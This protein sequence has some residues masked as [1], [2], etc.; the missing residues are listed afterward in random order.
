[1]NSVTRRAVSAFVVLAVTFAA[2]A[3]FASAADPATSP[4]DLIYAPER[5]APTVLAPFVK[6]ERM[7]GSHWPPI[8]DSPCVCAHKMVG[9]DARACRKWVGAPLYECKIRG[10][11]PES[12]CVKYGPFLPE[13]Y[14]PCLHADNRRECYVFAPPGS[15]CGD[16]KFEAS[17][18]SYV[19][20]EMVESLEDYRSGARVSVSEYDRDIATRT[21]WSEGRY[22]DLF[23]QRGVAWVLVNRLRDR[24]A[25][26]PNT[27]AGVCQQRGQFHTW[28]SDRSA[29]EYKDAVG[30]RKQSTEYISARMIIDGVLAGRIADPTNGAQF[31]YA[32]TD[33]VESVRPSWAND[34]ECDVQSRLHVFCRS[35]L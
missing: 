31:Y 21:V 14:C 29:A 2:I 35:R 10:K 22:D 19:R 7:G 16:W 8:A 9:A 3:T 1:M 33:G 23:G 5:M 12:L 6:P 26:F 34:M 32:Q 30:L 17:D 18:Q 24:R 25:R 13:H 28:A 4:P 27:L 11:T 20:P 15:K